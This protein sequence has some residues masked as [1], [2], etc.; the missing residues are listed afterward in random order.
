M[1]LKGGKTQGELPGGS[2]MLDS[3]TFGLVLA[4]LVAWIFAW[5]LIA[6][7]VAISKQ[8]DPIGGLVQGLTLGPVGVLFVALSRDESSQLR[9]DKARASRTSGGDAGSG[10]E[11]RKR[12]EL[13]T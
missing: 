1:N 8:Q 11:T 12:D 4:I 3:L 2:D 13:Y 9:Q 6:A 7:V 5:G 10:Q